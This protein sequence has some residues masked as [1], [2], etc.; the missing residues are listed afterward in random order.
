MIVSV[1]IPVYNG[2]AFVGEALDSV[3]AQTFSSLEVI[4]V[5]DGSSDGSREVLEAFPG[6]SLVCQDNQGVAA[7]RNAGLQ[8]CSGSFVSFLDQDDLWQA[9]KTASQVQYLLD[10]PVVDIVSCH[11]DFFL[12]GI[13]QKPDWLRQER[14]SQPGKNFTLGSCLL[15]RAL[16]DSVGNFDTNYQMASDNDWFVR[17]LDMGLEIAHTEEVYLKRR[18]HRGN[19]SQDPRSVREMLAIHRQSI[20]R[21]RALST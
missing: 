2:Q 9:G 6:V 17:A 10:H 19:H 7:A 13:D 11:T 16:F 5:D 15:R 20:H 14:F 12:D 21:K 3:F 1:I 18:L 4:A 8:H